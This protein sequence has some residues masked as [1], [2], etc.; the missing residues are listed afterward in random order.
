MPQTIKVGTADFKVAK[1]PSIL[2]SRG[3]GSCV[4]TCIYDSTLKIGAVSHIILPAQSSH[5]NLNPKR[6]ADTAL[7]L[8]FAELKRL[9]SQRAHLSAY[10]VGGA[11]MFQNLDTFINGI[12]EQNI[13]AVKHIME[14]QGIPIVGLDVGGTKGRNVTFDVGSGKITIASKL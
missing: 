8:V 1:A 7:P 10:L 3:I 11:S 13:T 6:F 4:V 14:Q 2:E 5:L 12:G 9:G